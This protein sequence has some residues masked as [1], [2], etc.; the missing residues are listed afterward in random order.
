MN[1]GFVALA[2]NDFHF[3]DIRIH[4]CDHDFNFVI[5]V[6]NVGILIGFDKKQ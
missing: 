1:I 6:L 2:G 5:I 3:F 4:D